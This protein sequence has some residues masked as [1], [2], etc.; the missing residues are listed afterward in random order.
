MNPIFI[1]LNDI[2]AVSVQQIFSNVTAIMALYVVV[3]LFH[4][5]DF[6]EHANRV[7]VFTLICSGIPTDAIGG[8]MA[9]GVLLGQLSMKNFLSGGRPFKISIFV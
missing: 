3:V 6:I 5:C 9:R 7:E 4:P 8:T 1:S 2:G